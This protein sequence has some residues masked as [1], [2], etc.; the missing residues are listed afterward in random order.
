[1]G[2]KRDALSFPVTM[3]REPRGIYGWWTPRAGWNN[4]EERQPLLPQTLM[5]QTPV[6]QRRSSQTHD[7]ASAIGHRLRSD[8][9]RQ[10]ACFIVLAVLFVGTV[11]V[12]L[13]IVWTQ[14]GF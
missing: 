2:I 6:P 5:P 12:S 9:G 11:A 1:M 3:N 7:T 8:F 10:V 4:V 14:G 13:A